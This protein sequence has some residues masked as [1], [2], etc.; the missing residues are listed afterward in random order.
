MVHKLTCPLL[1]NLARPNIF[2]PFMLSVAPAVHSGE[3]CLVN[4]AEEV[5]TLVRGEPSQVTRLTVG[6]YATQLWKKTQSLIRRSGDIGDIGVVMNTLGGGSA[7]SPDVG[8]TTNSTL[9]FRRNIRLDLYGYMT[10]EIVYAVRRDRG[11]EKNVVFSV[12]ITFDV[13]NICISGDEVRRIYGTGTLSV[14]AGDT[15]KPKSN[16]DT[17]GMWFSEIY[18]ESDSD[19]TRA[20]L[21][22]YYN[23]SGCMRGVLLQLSSPASNR[24]E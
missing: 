1:Q 13:N 24:S 16:S 22:F 7:D 17:P 21:V 6:P 14:P 9:P 8:L 12:N 15:Y 20:P 19:L 3:N 23:P 18:A 10:K 2:I 4:S 11:D 5:I